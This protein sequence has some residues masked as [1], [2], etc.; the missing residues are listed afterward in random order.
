MSS[1]FLPHVHMGVACFSR[2]LRWGA[3]PLPLP[4]L[5]TPD[6]LPAAFDSLWVAILH[7]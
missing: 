4:S 1:C 2:H 3:Q 6:S 5:G 7:P